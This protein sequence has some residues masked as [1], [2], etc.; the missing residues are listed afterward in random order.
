MTRFATPVIVRCPA[1]D[2]LVKKQRFAS[3]NLSR[4]YLFPPGFQAI[5]QGDL[6]CPHCKAEVDTDGLIPIV[7]LDAQWKKGVWAGILD[8]EVRSD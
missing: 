5:A 2:G 4:D 8:F 3:I 7:R 1:C 6:I